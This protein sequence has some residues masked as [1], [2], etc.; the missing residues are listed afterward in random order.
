MLIDY[1][2]RA[3]QLLY[4][5]LSVAER[6]ELY[7]VFRRV[8]A[9]LHI[10]GLPETYAEWRPDRKRH[11]DRDLVYGNYTAQLFRQYRRHLG[12]WR[13]EILLQVQAL[14]VPDEVRKLLR[15]ERVDLLSHMIRAYSIV[16]WLSLQ[17][18]VEGLLIPPQ[19]WDRVRELDR[20]AG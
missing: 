18:L 10:P 13:Y 15:L 14:V 20:G 11:L 7:D 19:Y 12:A 8:G 17:W 1:S 16:E 5:P 3:H 6:Q 2:E 9:G 4:G